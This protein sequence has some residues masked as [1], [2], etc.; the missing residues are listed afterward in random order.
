MSENYNHIEEMQKAAEATGEGCVGKEAT[1]VRNIVK[2]AMG[3]L[4]IWNKIDDVRLDN[5]FWQINFSDS[6]SREEREK[7]QKLV[8]EMLNIKPELIKLV[9]VYG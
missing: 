7:L 1:K 5:I 4:G 3:Q 6:M 9:A 2:K 8:A